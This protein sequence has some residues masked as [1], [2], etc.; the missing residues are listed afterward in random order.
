MLEFLQ[1]YLMVS[2]SWVTIMISLVTLGASGVLFAWLVNYSLNQEAWGEDKFCAIKTVCDFIGNI[3]YCKVPKA[4]IGDDS[5]V[6]YYKGNELE[7]VPSYEYREQYHLW[8]RILGQYY[9]PPCDD[10]ISLMR[11]HHC[12]KVS[13]YVRRAD[14]G[15][16]LTYKKIKGQVSTEMEVKA[17]SCFTWRGLLAAVVLDL[18]FYVFT[19]APVATLSILGLASTIYSTRWLSGK[20]AKTTQAKDN[21]EERITKLEK[22]DDKTE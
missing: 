18:T 16:N 8:D 9:S 1:N 14:G 4:I 20:L 13:T 22:D 15:C 11:V 21:H 19:L 2:M 5:Y 7:K 12:E 17:R 6:F 3:T 10:L